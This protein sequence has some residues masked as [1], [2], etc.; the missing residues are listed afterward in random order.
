MEKQYCNGAKRNKIYG[1]GMD[2]S[3]LGYRK[4]ESSCEYGNDGLGFHKTRGISQFCDLLLTSPEGLSCTQSGYFRNER[5][6]K[7]RVHILR[8]LTTWL[9]FIYTDKS[10]LCHPT[11]LI[12]DLPVNPYRTNVENR[13]SL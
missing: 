8:Q 2:S 7:E 9:S 4:V 5:D 1:R 13:V 10:Y 6:L 11:S 3:G 12:L